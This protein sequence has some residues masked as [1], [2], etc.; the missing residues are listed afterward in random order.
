MPLLLLQ[1]HITSAN[2]PCPKAGEAEQSTNPLNTIYNSGQD[3]DDD[4][5]VA[6]VGY[7]RG[8]LVPAAA[9]G[10]AKEGK[11][12]RRKGVGE[13]PS[14]I[15]LLNGC[16]T[17]IMAFYCP[18]RVSLTIVVVVSALHVVVVVPALHVV[19]VVACVVAVVMGDSKMAALLAIGNGHRN[20]KRA[21]AARC[22]RRRRRRHI[23]A[24]VSLSVF[25]CGSVSICLRVSE[26]C[27]MPQQWHQLRARTTATR[28][29]SRG[30][31]ADRELMLADKKQVEK[32]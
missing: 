12:A 27:Q 26:G 14:C 24:C 8:L 5:G 30:S 15:A 2:K 28:R 3:D 9:G 31:W 4:D 11:G 13:M 1:S 25:V 21:F 29:R 16:K 6:S 20:V 22:Q 10:V 32:Q 7:R 18:G 19:V 23:G 17:F